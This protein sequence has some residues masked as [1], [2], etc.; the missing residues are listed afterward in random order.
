MKIKPSVDLRGIKPELVVAM[1]LCEPVV[2]RHAEFVVTSVCDGKHMARSKHYE[3]LAMD[4]RTR[5]IQPEMLKPCLEEIKQA[6]GP[7]YDVVLEGDHIH[8]EFDPK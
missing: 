6:L 5:E 4:I 1:I 8:I 7:Q 2:S 3:G